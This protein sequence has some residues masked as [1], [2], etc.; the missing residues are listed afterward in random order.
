MFERWYDQTNNREVVDVRTFVIK[1]IND[2]I[3][4]I[5]IKPVYFLNFPICKYDLEIRNT[6]TS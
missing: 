5:L 2:H 4:N 1:V 3:T 6:L